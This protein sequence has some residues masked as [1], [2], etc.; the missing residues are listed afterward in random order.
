MAFTYMLRC[1][2]GSFY[3][4]STSGPL[5]KRIAEHES[6]AYPGY[7]SRRRPVQLIW[8]ESF[9]QI[10]DA[11]AAERKIKGWSRIKKRALIEGDWER[12]SDAAR[13]RG[14]DCR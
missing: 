6:G 8:S 9:E 11:V 4:G 1:A 13:R 10:T 12:V 7:T 2:D 3:V 5:D 14:G